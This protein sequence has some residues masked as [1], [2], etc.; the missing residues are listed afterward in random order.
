MSF[1]TFR[2]RNGVTKKAGCL[3]DHGSCVTQSK[4]EIIPLAE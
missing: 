3:G 1:N 4:N 2:R